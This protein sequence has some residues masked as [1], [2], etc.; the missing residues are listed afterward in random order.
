MMT[1]TAMAK[2]RAQ[3]ISCRWSLKYVLTAL[4]N[5]LIS[6]LLFNV[7]ERYGLRARHENGSPV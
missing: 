7:G 2:T 5:F 1:A 6:N 4:N 3:I